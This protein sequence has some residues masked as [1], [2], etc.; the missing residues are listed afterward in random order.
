MA[1]AIAQQLH[2]QPRQI[3]PQKLVSP[4]AHDAYLLGRYYWFAGD[5]DTASEYYQKAINLQPDYA[6]AWSGVSNSLV[7]KAVDNEILPE[8]VLPR[9]EVA[10]RKALE[11]DDQLAEAHHTMAALCLFVRW[12][13]G[14]ADTETARA[15]ELDPNVA[16]AHHL[17]AYVLEVLDR[18]QEA[19]QEQKKATDLDPLLRPHAMARLLF[20]LR[21][22]DA[23][24]KEA[25]LRVAA[26]P[27]AVLLHDLLANIYRHKGMDKESEQELERV[28]VLN[29][30]QV[31]ATAAHRAFARG[32]MKAVL[33][34]Q[35]S[36]L[37]KQSR[38]NY[39]SPYDVACL[40]ARLRRKDETLRYLE[41]AYQQ[42]TPWLVMLQDEPDFDFL[43]SE[44]RYRA[45]VTS[46]G[47]PPAF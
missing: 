36:E 35:L 38:K 2:S 8:Q 14:Q 12:D 34:W 3:P 41:E 42:R 44:P 23:A 20:R 7:L 30:D 43:H 9:A 47:L 31:A 15:V 45:I 4:G 18:K 21:Q 24:L 40:Y 37:K 5:A 11:L 25:R 10:A 33:E 32:G 1:Q 22:F 13:F 6:A 27:Q 16:E 39:V 29:G 17:R 28:Q 26:R 46:M 19:L